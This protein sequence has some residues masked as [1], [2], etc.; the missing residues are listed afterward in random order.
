MPLAYLAASIINMIWASCG[1]VTPH[2]VNDFVRSGI[3]NAVSFDCQQTSLSELVI[4][5]LGKDF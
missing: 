4:G 1:F 5:P 2:R 3:N